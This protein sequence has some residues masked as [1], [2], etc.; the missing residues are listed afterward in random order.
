MVYTIFTAVFE[1]GYE[2]VFNSEEFR[3]RLEVYNYICKKQ[4]G[5]GHGCLEEIR[6]R[7]MPA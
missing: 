6:C 7:P 4:P 3:N 5:K 1:D 2:I